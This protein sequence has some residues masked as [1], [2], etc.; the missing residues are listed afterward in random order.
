[1][2]ATSSRVL[3]TFIM[4]VLIFCLLVSGCAKS[5]SVRLWWLGKTIDQGYQAIYWL[6][7]GNQVFIISAE[8]GQTLTVDYD[9]KVNKGTLDLKLNSPSGDTIWSTRL[10]ATEASS[11]EVVLEN[12]GQYTLQVVGE[13]NRGSFKI[14]WTAQ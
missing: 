14:H 12:S 8:A 13:D 3:Q 9:V 7:D 2:K 10:N 6:F 4:F 5:S 11:T 1:M